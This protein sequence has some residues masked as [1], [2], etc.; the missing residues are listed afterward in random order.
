MRTL[1]LYR[2]H[3]M[4]LTQRH[5]AHGSQPSITW[6][7]AV[8]LP[9]CLLTHDMQNRRILDQ[10]FRSAGVEAQPQLETNSMITLWSSLRFGGW[11][12]ILPA[13]FRLLLDG[14]DGIIALPLTEPDVTQAVGFVVSDYEPL[15]PVARALLDLARTLDRQGEFDR[16]PSHK[17]RDLSAYSRF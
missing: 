17:R 15:P 5:G 10:M 14:L 1:P 8:A 3:F 9:L 2:E 4:L 16:V 7:E 12:T 6:A 13:S 11:S